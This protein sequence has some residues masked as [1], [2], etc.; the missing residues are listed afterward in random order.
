MKIY[1]FEHKVLG[2]G[3]LCA[4]GCRYHGRYWYQLFKSHDS[5]DCDPEFE[6]KI[7]TGI[8]EYHKFGMSTL[9]GLLDLC[10][11]F[12]VEDLLEHGFDL[13]EFEVSDDSAVFNDGQVVFDSRTARRID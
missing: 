4:D 12:T 9:E 6:Q 8:Q 3:P 11:S 13:F 7:P 1:R 2:F 5:V 10:Y